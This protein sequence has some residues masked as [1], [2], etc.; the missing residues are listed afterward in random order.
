MALRATSVGARRAMKKPLVPW[1]C[2][3]V[4]R[5]SGRDGCANAGHSSPSGRTR[6]PLA[7][8]TASHS[9]GFERADGVD[10]RPAGPHALGGGA[11]ERELELRERRRAPAQVGPLREDAETRARRVD[12]RAVEAV[13]LRRQRRPV[14]LDDRDVGAAHRREVL[15]QLA[16]AAPGRSRPPSPRRAAARSSRPA[17]RRGR[18]RARRP[19]SR[20]RDPRAAS[21]GSAA[22]S[23][24]SATSASST[25][26]TR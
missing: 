16:R 20:R 12:E 23:V 5:N 21:R 13:E 11:E 22:R 18:G 19:A 17:R 25:R 24:P 15:A 7:S 10:D 14:R 26:S 2:G 6:R 1:T 9:S 3:S 4:S 8:T